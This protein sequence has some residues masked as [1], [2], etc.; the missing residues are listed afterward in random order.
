[1]INSKELKRRIRLG[2]FSIPDIARHLNINTSTF[3]RKMNKGGDGF[4]VGEAQ[5]IANLLNLTYEEVNSI[6]FGTEV[7]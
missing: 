2:G 1:M 6:F 7:A 5:K 3:Y 4:S